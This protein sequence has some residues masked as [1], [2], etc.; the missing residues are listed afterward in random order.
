VNLYQLSLSRQ[1]PASE[2]PNLLGAVTNV[3]RVNRRSGPL[4]ALSFAVM[5]FSLVTPLAGN[6]QT[7]I[8]YPSG[9]ASSSSQIW[10]EN[11]AKLAGSSIQL[12]APNAGS[13]NNIWYKSPVSVQAFTTTFTWT[14]TCPASPATCGDGMGFMIISDPN[15]TPAGFTY[16]GY[17]GGQFSWSKCSGNGDTSCPAIDSILVKFDLYNNQA[18][19][20]GAN[21]TGFY[22][23]GTYPQAP[24]N[25]QYNMAPSGINMESGHLMRATLSYNGSVLTETVTDTVTGATYTN[26]YTANIPSLVAGNIAYV[27]FGGG[28]GAA[29]VTQDLQ[30]WTYTV[31]SIGQA[32]PPT[33]SPVNGTYTKAQSVSISSASSGSVICYNTTGSPKTNGSNG[34]SSGTLYTGPITVSSSQTLYAIAGGSG[35]GDSSVASASYVIQ[36]PTATQAAAPTFSPGG[37]TYSAAESVKVASSSSGAVVCYNTTGSPKTNGSNGCSSGTLYTGAVTVSSSET[38]YAVAGGTGYN[39][40]PV[41]SAAYTIQAAASGSSQSVINF[42]SGFAGSSSQIWLENNAT[43]SGSLIHLVPSTV[44]NASNFW[45]KTPE[46]IQAFTTTFTFHIDCSND[47]SNCGDGLGFMIICACEGGNP[48]YNPSTGK[49]GYTYSG[50][51]GGQ[52]SWS[53]CVSPFTPS[54]AT[55]FNNGS[56]G[57]NGSTLTQLPDNILVKFDNYNNQTGTPGANFTGYYTD[58]EYPQAPY[59]PQYDMTSAGINLNSGHV[60]SATLTYNG[61]TLTETLTDTVTNATYTNSYAANIPAAIT[62]STGF[63][64]FGGGTGAALDDVYLHSWTYTV[65]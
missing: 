11:N 7:V 64:G 52:F 24:N 27:G 4:V 21:L 62:G 42:P 12:T 1:E 49:P 61:T 20:P 39:D 41:A 18:G 31:Q 56:N 51:S 60:F 25:P 40:S 22:S 45:F 47:P 35:Y 33:F 65:Q 3:C 63:I 37:G 5:M 6:G 13:A 58:G 29:T 23:G 34:C 30:S 55:C 32:A 48:T 50:F 57:D 46:N 15:S 16:S 26:N 43:L 44:H 17:S 36:S 9:F 28:T 8:N 38:L 54:S 2:A 59:N 19:S 10:L 14:A 53:Q